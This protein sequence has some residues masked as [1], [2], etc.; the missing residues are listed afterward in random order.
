MSTGISGRELGEFAGI[1]GGE[2]GRRKRD[3][4]GEGVEMRS[5]FA[6]KRDWS[7]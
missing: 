4:L 6:L 7:G 3:F 1:D 2:R 5:G